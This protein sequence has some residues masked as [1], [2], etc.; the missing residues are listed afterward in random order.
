MGDEEVGSW[1]WQGACLKRKER[2][3]I[4]ESNVQET[5]IQS[6][7]LVAKNLISPGTSLESFQKKSQK[8]HQEQKK[9]NEDQDKLIAQM[10]KTIT[11]Q[12]DL[13]EKIAIHPEL[14]HILQSFKTRATSQEILGQV[15]LCTFSVFQVFFL[16]TF[17]PL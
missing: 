4:T 5:K 17:D 10:Q 15:F 9:R 16:E 14:R 12:K 8:E 1:G 7:L 6:L 3:L 13:I 11:D 2:G